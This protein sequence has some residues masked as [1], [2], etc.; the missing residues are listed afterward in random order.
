MMMGKATNKI[1]SMMMMLRAA[2][3]L[4]LSTTGTN[5]V[6]LGGGNSF[7]VCE[8]RVNSGHV[9][10]EYPLN[11]PLYKKD[12]SGDGKW[13]EG[14]ISNFDPSTG[15]YEVAWSDGLTVQNYDADS[16]AGFV[17]NEYYQEQGLLEEDDEDNALPAAEEEALITGEEDAG[18]TGTTGMADEENEENGDT[19]DAGQHV[20]E[21]GTPVFT[22]NDDG[23]LMGGTIIDYTPGYYMIQWETTGPG[24]Y[25]TVEDDD[26][27]IDRLVHPFPEEMWHDAVDLEEKE[28]IKEAIEE[29]G[30]AIEDEIEEGPEIG[31]VDDTFDVIAI[32]YTILGVLGLISV[33]VLVFARHQR[34]SM[35]SSFMTIK[36]M[37]SNWKSINSSSSK[38]NWKSGEVERRMSL[39]TRLSAQMDS[40]RN[41]HNVD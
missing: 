21:K 31:S 40:N 10:Q 30:D 17:Y 11:T 23:T 14:S 32:A 20:Y 37:N 5:Y 19:F 28:D 33:V 25:Q 26:P 2:L 13:I 35:F 6:Y 34:L 12:P 41:L 9:E 39:Q 8:A 24:E 7:S 18:G 4:L 15:T 3:L 38:M 27:E 22:K 29:V 1:V 16:I 36:G